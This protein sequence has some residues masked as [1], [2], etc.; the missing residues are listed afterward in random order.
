MGN[1]YSAD[2][3]AKDHIHTDITCNT[4]E[5]QKKYRLGTVSNRLLRGLNAFYWIQNLALSFCSDSNR[6]F[7]MKVSYESERGLDRNEL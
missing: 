3:I 6:L 5:P 7:R 4:E 2:H 1:L